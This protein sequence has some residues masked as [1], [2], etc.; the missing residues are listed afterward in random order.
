MK[1]TNDSVILFTNYGMGNGPEEL[2]LILAGKYLNIINQYEEL[3]GA[4]CF[5]TEGVKLVI[6]GSPVLDQLHALEKRGVR[7]IACSTCLDYF[8]LADKVKVGIV[9]G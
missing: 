8:G 6:E 4:I 5:Y 3:P 1:S 2:R 7:L 9:G